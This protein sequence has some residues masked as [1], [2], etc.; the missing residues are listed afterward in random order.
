M[1]DPVPQAKNY[2]DTLFGHGLLTQQQ[3]RAYVFREVFGFSRQKTAGELSVS[4]S[5]VDNLRRAA[6][7]KIETAEDTL[8]Q[9]EKFEEW[10]IP[11]VDG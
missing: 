7:E 5:R 2:A 10:D 11:D 3:A 6:M 1:G 9:L 4:K 8:T